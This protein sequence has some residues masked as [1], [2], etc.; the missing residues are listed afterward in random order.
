[1]YLSMLYGQ[2]NAVMSTLLYT[3]KACMK[4]MPSRCPNRL[5]V[6]SVAKHAYSTGMLPTCFIATGEMREMRDETVYVV[7]LLKHHR[8]FCWL[9]V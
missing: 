2:A 1:M 7:Q 5:T 8:L 9:K 4:N 6:L 3:N